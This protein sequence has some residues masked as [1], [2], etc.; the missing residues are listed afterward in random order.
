MGAPTPKRASRGRTNTHTAAAG[1][2]ALDL[3]SLTKAEAFPDLHLPTTPF[4]FLLGGR[5]YELA[6][7]RDADWKQAWQ[8]AGN[9]FLLMRTALIGAED[10][11]TDPTEAELEAARDRLRLVDVDA[12]PA[13]Q[14]PHGDAAPTTDEGDGDSPAEAGGV[15]EPVVTL[16]D[17]FASA[18][19]P[20][21]KL[22]ALFA[23]WHDY[24]K[25]KLSEEQ[26]ILPALLGATG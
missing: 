14:Q 6:D 12:Q 8:L 19:L 26:G 24:Y 21:W 3:D 23:R 4:R 22:N 13:G 25:I 20:G 18:D 16:I 5:W 11:V 15:E 10:P 7:P 2:G 9:P 1:P 17:R